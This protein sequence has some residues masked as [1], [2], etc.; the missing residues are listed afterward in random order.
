MDT[1]DAWAAHLKER[2]R[3]GNRVRAARMRERR[4]KTRI[5]VHGRLVAPVPP[6]LHGKRPTY[7]NYSCRCVR[8]TRVSTRY[9]SD[10][11]AKRRRRE[12]EETNGDHHRQR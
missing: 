9:A 4:K 3:A 2:E 7:I 10:Y 6:E 12:M 8:C 5:L 11:E 1:L